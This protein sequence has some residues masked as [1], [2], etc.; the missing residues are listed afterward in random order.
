MAWLA[1]PIDLPSGPAARGRGGRR[2]GRRF[3]RLLELIRSH[4]STL[5]FVNSRRLANGGRCAQRSGQRACPARTRLAGSRGTQ[6][7]GGSAQSRTHQGARRHVLARARHRHG[8][9]RSGRPDRSAAVGGQRDATDRARR[10]PGG[11]GER[12]NHL[13]EVPRRSRGVRGRR[14]RDARRT[15]GIDALSAESARCTRPADRRDGRARYLVGRRAVRADQ[16]RRAVC[17]LEPPGLRGRARHALRALP[18]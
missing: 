4:Q 3:T 15:G 1:V 18:V 5:L 9:N 13:S 14:A 6:R 10:A 16:T 8:R 11:R 12:G 17:R 7:G 2:S